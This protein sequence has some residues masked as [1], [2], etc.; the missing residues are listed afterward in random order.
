[1]EQALIVFS[2]EALK[3]SLR[4]LNIEGEP[5]F[6]GKEVAETLGY[7]N[8]RDALMRHVDKRN[9]R[10]L[11]RKD[12]TV[13]VASESDLSNELD[14][15]IESIFGNKARQITIINESGLYD[16]IID[17][18]LPEAKEWRYWV[19]S[20]VLPKIRRYGVYI[21]GL[22]NIADLDDFVKKSVEYYNLHAYEDGFK[23]GYKQA[24]I[25]ID[26]KCR[27]LQDKETKPKR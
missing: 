20:E 22:G 18:R 21:P 12:W 4:T 10:V 7:S 13:K 1:M 16:L 26:T 24:F 2:N 11:T 5:Y 14:G 19:T 6:I 15:Q 17:S 27:E 23:E 25:D 9:K 3:T 8:T